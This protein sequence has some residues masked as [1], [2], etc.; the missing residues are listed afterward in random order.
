VS[1][2]T[3]DELIQSL[4]ANAPSLNG[5]KYRAITTW[6]MTY[7]PK[8][9]LIKG[10]Y[11]LENYT[12]EYKSNMT[13]PR[14]SNNVTTALRVQWDLYVLC[15]TRHEQGHRDLILA[16][17]NFINGEF[18]KIEPQEDELALKTNIENIMNL[19]LAG[20]KTVESNYDKS[21]Q[22]GRTQGAYFD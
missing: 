18:S 9:K 22:N 11:V 10:K 6:Q 8:I 7:K 2:K 4:N 13:L 12:I 14:L 21:T 20:F 15:L 3:K 19:I 1:G 5:A 17:A 16:A